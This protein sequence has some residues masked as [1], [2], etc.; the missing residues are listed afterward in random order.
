MRGGVGDEG[1]IHQVLEHASGSKTDDV[2]VQR[3][4]LGAVNRVVCWG[5]TGDADI[6]SVEAAR[7]A[8]DAACEPERGPHGVGGA[9]G[10]PARLCLSPLPLSIRPSGPNPPSNPPS[11][12]IPNT[13]VRPQFPLTPPSLTIITS[14]TI[15]PPPYPPIPTTSSP[16]QPPNA[17]CVWSA[18]LGPALFPLWPPPRPPRTLFLFHPSPTLSRPAVAGRDVA[19]DGC[20]VGLTDVAFSLA[21]CSHSLPLSLFPSLPPFRSPPPSFPLPLPPLA[22]AG[23]AEFLLNLFDPLVAQLQ[24]VLPPPI[25]S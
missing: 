3:L 18:R 19:V 21:L 12:I 6:H 17:P 23:T 7:R 2:D 24:Q 25:G 22:R 14:S 16:E 8:R 13:T 1:P 15:R 4:K 10:R 20:N 5:L 9:A 11:F